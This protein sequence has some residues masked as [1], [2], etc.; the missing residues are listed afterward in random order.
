M[1]DVHATVMQTD[2]CAGLNLAA[3]R[4][5]AHHLSTKGKT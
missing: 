5:I 1:P 3:V 2:F 4:H